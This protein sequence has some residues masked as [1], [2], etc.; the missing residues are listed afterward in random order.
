MIFLDMYQH[1]HQMDI[2]PDG[3]VP[4]LMDF[5]ILLSRNSLCF[6][7]INIQNSPWGYCQFYLNTE[8]IDKVFAIY[9]SQFVFC[10]IN[11]SG[12]RKA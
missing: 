11:V 5:Q 1:C 8:A 3:D 10:S 4:A 2:P 9:V 7:I 12:A 6:E